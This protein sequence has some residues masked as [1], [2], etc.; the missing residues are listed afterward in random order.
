MKIKCFYKCDLRNMS[1]TPT[2]NA[3][4]KISAQISYI[5][6]DSNAPMAGG[7]AALATGERGH[8]SSTSAKD[9]ATASTRDVAPSYDNQSHHVERDMIMAQ[10]A[11]NEDGPASDVTPEEL[12]QLREME[13]LVDEKNESLGK[14]LKETREKYVEVSNFYPEL[15]VKNDRYLQ[16]SG[17]AYDETRRA[18][19][20]T[21]KLFREGSKGAVKGINLSDAKK[22]GP[23]LERGIQMFSKYLDE[24]GNFRPCLEGTVDEIYDYLHDNEDFEAFKKE[25]NVPTKE[26]YKEKFEKA[27]NIVAERY[28]SDPEIELFTCKLQ[29]ASAEDETKFYAVGTFFK[30]AFTGV[31]KEE[32]AEPSPFLGRTEA[33]WKSNY[34]KIGVVERANIKKFVDSLGEFHK[35]TIYRWSQGKTDSSF[36]KLLKCPSIELLMLLDAINLGT[37]KSRSMYRL[38]GVNEATFPE[39]LKIDQHSLDLL[40]VLRFIAFVVSLETETME[41]YYSLIMPKS[42]EQLYVDVGITSKNLKERYSFNDKPKTKNK[43]AKENVMK[44]ATEVS[45]I[46]DP[47]D[48]I[49]AADLEK[50]RLKTLKEKTD[51]LT[52]NH[53]NKMKQISELSK[54][55]Q[56]EIGYSAEE[57][58]LGDYLT[59]DV[60]D[61]S[62]AYVVSQLMLT[63]QHR[64]TPKEVIE[65]AERIANTNKDKPFDKTL[66]VTV[67][68][69]FEI[70]YTSDSHKN[71]TED[72]EQHA[73]QKY[74]LYKRFRCTDETIKAFGPFFEY[75]QDEHTGTAYERYT[76]LLSFIAYYGNSLQFTHR[77]V[78]TTTKVPAKGR[79]FT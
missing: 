41:Y 24:R 34:S 78:P 31:L 51:A 52:R 68:P 27:R 67:T 54:A 36:M 56:E 42:D 10:Q 19:V 47:S 23:I 7:E 45:M 17:A 60:L 65:H 58:V 71:Y 72:F 22:V 5:A 4:A 77:V 26:A 6:Q 53:A 55:E 1:F 57:I 38:L 59:P 16:Q 12:E 25:Y 50:E 30:D 76:N 40:K 66:L 33:E 28:E 61:A 20:N 74:I 9:Q 49:T 69:D 35:E 15:G 8:A 64:D 2:F 75:I 43:K 13:K 32:H 39:E 14:A 79:K 46:I 21:A 3:D 48:V 37:V 11:T 63:N 44:S 29:T 62:T 70:E 73:Q 18:L